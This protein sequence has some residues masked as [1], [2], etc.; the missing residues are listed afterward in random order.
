VVNFIGF[1]SLTILH[2]IG[3]KM[4]EYIIDFMRPVSGEYIKNV[5]GNA[6]ENLGWRPKDSDVSVAYASYLPLAD[7]VEG[8][9]DEGGVWAGMENAYEMAIRMPK[10]KVSEHTTPAMKSEPMFGRWEYTKVRFASGHVR[11]GKPGEE[12]LV[13]LSADQFK[14]FA[15]AVYQVME[16]ELNPLL[17]KS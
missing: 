8:E 12:R 1:K 13:A 4:V 15:I 5:L 6:A 16:E 9:G 10:P 2:L 7:R 3:D 14:Q 11:A 17:N